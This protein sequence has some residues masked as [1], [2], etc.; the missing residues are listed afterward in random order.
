MI[1]GLVNSL[2]QAYFHQNQGSP[3]GNDQMGKE[4]RDIWGM[5]RE[6]SM[7]RLVM[8]MGWLQVFERPLEKRDQI[9]MGLIWNVKKAVRYIHT[10]TIHM[11]QESKFRGKSRKFSNKLALFSKGMAAFLW[12]CE[13]PIMGRGRERAVNNLSGMI[14]RWL[15][16]WINCEHHFS[17]KTFRIY[18]QE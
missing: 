8:E 18:K 13:L 6:E 17:A 10:H 11:Y 4:H 9:H 3:E 15:W 1:T 16:H 12:S 5:L 7:L 14:W 2:Q